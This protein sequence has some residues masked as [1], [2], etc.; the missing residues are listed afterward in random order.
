MTLTVA[1]ANHKGGVGKTATA[2]ALGVLLAMGGRRVLMV[3]TDPQSSL[4]HSCGVHDAG[5]RSLAD[6]LGGSSPG[7]L[8]LSGAIVDL[9]PNLSLCPADIALSAS[10]L[11]LTSRLGRENALKKALA[12]VAGR[13]DLCLIDC[14]PSL[15][16]LTVGALVASQAVLIP[17]QPQAADLRGLRLFLDTLEIIKAE[18]NPALQILGVLV[19]FFDGRLT[20]H[21]AAL[22]AIQAAGLP[23]LPVNIGRSVRVA[24]AMGAGQSVVTYDPGNPQAENYRQLAEVFLSWLKSSNPI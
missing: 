8:P 1:I 17:T 12:T 13:F 15:S 7:K 5:G 6:V 14:P 18:L 9:A 19:T 24:E 23:V 20:H 3:D 22:E 10:E 16:L 11:G 21:R 4:T 2:Q